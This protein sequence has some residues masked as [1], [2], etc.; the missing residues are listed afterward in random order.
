MLLEVALHH[1]LHVVHGD[2]LVGVAPAPAVEGAVD[3]TGRPG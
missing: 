1:R 3:S 2:L